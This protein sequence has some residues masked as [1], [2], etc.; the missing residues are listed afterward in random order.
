[1][2]SR[3]AEAAMPLDDFIE[4]VIKQLGTD[5]EEILVGNARLFRGNPGPSEGAFV[6][7]FNAS[8]PF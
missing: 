6:T 8:L 3:E 4:G 5:A 2:N 7:E 1:M